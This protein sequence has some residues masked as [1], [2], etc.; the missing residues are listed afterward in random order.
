MGQTVRGVKRMTAAFGQ[1]FR[2]C[3]RGKRRQKKALRRAGGL[4]GSIVK[5]I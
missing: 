5:K 3:A 1:I 2:C 4:D